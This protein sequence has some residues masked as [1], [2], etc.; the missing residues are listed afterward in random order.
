MLETVKT[1]L[2]RGDGGV[3]VHECRRCG[4]SVETAEAECPACGSNDI[5]TLSTN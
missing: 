3:A 5:V 4:T 2:F 1:L